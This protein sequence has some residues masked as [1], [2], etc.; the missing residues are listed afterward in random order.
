MDF[1]SDLEKTLLIPLWARSKETENNDPIIKDS[2]SSDIIQKLGAD[3]SYMDGAWQS[4]L[5]IAIR[6]KIIHDQVGKFIS[7]HPKSNIISLGCGLDGYFRNF[8]NDNVCWYDIDLPD[9]IKLRSKFVQESDSHFLIGSSVL[10][11]SWFDK[12]KDRELPTLIIGEGLLYYLDY[13]DAKVLLNNITSHFD[14]VEFLIELIGKAMVGFARFNDSIKRLGTGSRAEFKWSL[15]NSRKMEL[16]CNELK[17]VEEWWMGDFFPSR[18]KHIKYLFMVPL[19][20][21]LFSNRIIHLKKITSDKVRL[22]K[23]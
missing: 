13:E 3:L 7:L 20:K 18:W 5:A 2:W 10:D 16:W 1:K 15:L 4:Q 14:R 23:V 21:R 8:E 11:Y 22:Q 19:F 9:I 6:T 12:V 17:F